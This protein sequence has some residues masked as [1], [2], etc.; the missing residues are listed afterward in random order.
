MEAPDK[1][2]VTDITF[3][4]PHDGS[5]NPAVVLDPFSRRV[6]GWAIQGRQTTN[7]VLQALLDVV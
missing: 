4:R 6:V 1:S 5:A 7:V 3:T 2:W